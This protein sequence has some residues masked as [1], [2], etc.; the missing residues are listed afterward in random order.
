MSLLLLFPT[1]VDVAAPVFVNSGTASV[2]GATLTV[3]KPSGTLDGHL[4]LVHIQH[5]TGSQ[6]INP[7]PPDAGWNLISPGIQTNSSSS[8]WYYWKIAASE[9][10]T[11][12]W[13]GLPAN[14]QEAGIIVVSGADQTTPIHLTHLLQNT[15]IA[16]TTVALTLTTTVADCLLVAFAGQDQTA[17]SSWTQASMTERYDESL[18]TSFLTHCAYTETAAATGTYART[19]TASVAERISGALIAVLAAPSGI[20]GTAAVTQAADT[21]AASGQLGYTGTSAVTQAA[22]TSSATGTVAGPVTGTAA[23]S[24][25]SQM[26]SAA[27]QLGYSGTAAPSQAAHTST[28]TG[29]LGYS[30]TSA[31]SQANQTSV[32]SGQLGYS[33]TATPTQAANTAS[34]SGIFTAGGAIAGSAAVTQANQTAAATGK[35]GYSGTT[36]VSQASQTATANGK[37]GY[38]GTST[39]TQAANSAAATGTVT[40]PVTGSAATTQA[41]QTAAASGILRYIAI[42]ATSQASNTSVA[43]GVFFVPLTGTALVTQAN[44]TA[45]ASGSSLGSIVIRP[46]TGRTTRTASGITPRPF[47]TTTPRP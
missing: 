19:I 46:D 11:W 1:G 23:P 4:L 42:G 21:S 18:T 26:A 25:A 39:A 32:A 45:S 15:N 37:L 31:V 2:N 40:A 47:T 20:T 8:H 3:T 10:A 14:F 27:G 24:Q 28:A 33:G 13:T 12:D 36:A 9:P 35:L 34:A 43:S 17:T 38:T 5:V 30:G 44:Q 6:A 29:K 16:G 22:N 41:N 7:T